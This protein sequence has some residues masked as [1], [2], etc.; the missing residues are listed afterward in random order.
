MIKS[1]LLFLFVLGILLIIIDISKSSESCPT[2]KVIYRYIPRTFEQEQTQPDY[3]S[4]IF[5]Q[6]FTEPSTWNTNII[7]YSHRY[8][9]APNKYHISQD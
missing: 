6:M 8:L 1:I 2:Q 3:P 5:K 7:D 4:D 9:E